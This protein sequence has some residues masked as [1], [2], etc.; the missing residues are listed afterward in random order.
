LEESA[1]DP[2]SSTFTSSFLLYARY[3]TTITMQIT[4]AVVTALAS[5]GLVQ[6]CSEV[7]GVKMTFYGSPDND[8]AGST[9]IAHDCGRGYNAGGTGTY[10]DPLTF[11]SAPGEY[12]SCEIVYSPYL[13]KYIRLEDDCAQCSKSPSPRTMQW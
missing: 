10:A 13:K 3:P 8:P 9:A 5:F 12:K 1:P 4:L 6:A 2:D 11:A 7:S